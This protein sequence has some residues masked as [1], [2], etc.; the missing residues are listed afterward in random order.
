[1]ATEIERKYLI[2]NNTWK[3]QV[4]AQRHIRQGYL[5]NTD[6][7][8]VR[9]R[10]SG[11]KA[12]INIKG[13]TTARVR[14]EYEYPIPVAE[15]EELLTRMCQGALI[16]KTR[17]LVQHGQ[18]EW[19]I[20]V[21]EGENAGLVVA[22]VELDAVDETVDLPSWVGAEVTDDPRYLNMHLVRHPYSRW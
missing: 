16:I 15:A 4:H 21:F 1:M 18:H 6:L 2:L 5:A 20:D 19:E 7:C 9:V 14:S 22:E 8:S 12:D 11:D 13:M 10:C 3:G 17:Y